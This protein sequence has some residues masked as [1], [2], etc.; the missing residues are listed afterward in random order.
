MKKPLVKGG[1][2]VF[3]EIRNS[4]GFK[5]RTANKIEIE[6]QIQN[7]VNSRNALSNP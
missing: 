5:K 4:K 2:N 7:F 6:I 1:L 3:S